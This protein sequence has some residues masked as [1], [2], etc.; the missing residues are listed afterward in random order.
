MSIDPFKGLVGQKNVK[1]KLKFYLKAFNKTRVSPFLGFFGAKGLGKTAFAQ[2]FANNL[3]NQN[4]SQRV[5]LELNCS[6]IKNND[7]F[8][9]QIFIP[10]ILDNEITILFDEA[11]EL[12]RDLTMALLTILDTSDS[13]VREF[14]WKE[15]RYPFDF[16]KQTF[17]FAT[18]ESD[19]LFPPL[20]DRLTSIDFDSYSEKELGEIL[21]LS[22]DCDVCPNVLSKLSS[23]VRG[24]ARNAKM[25]A[26]DINL[27]SASE[28]IDLFDTKHYNKFCETLGI[29]PFGIT[30]T[31][32]QIIQVLSDCGACTLSMLG[33]KTGLS[34]TALRSDHEK[35]LLKQ[36]LMEIDTKRKLTFKGQ[37][38]AKKI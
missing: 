20:K 1:K 14:H 8:F 5:L 7:D 30:C 33:A 22:L 10:L 4:G 16:K 11:H 17:M 25:R 24:N 23:V 15:T 9:D 35:Y 37:K 2:K 18:T 34:T 32:K 28:N 29:L 27:Y 12:P 13:H 6:A 26:K 19:K 36:N 31:E 38:L 3:K 21:S